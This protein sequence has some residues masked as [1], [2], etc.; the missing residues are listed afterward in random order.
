M[1]VGFFQSPTQAVSRSTITRGM[2]D[3]NLGVSQIY[4]DTDNVNWTEH[5]VMEI[6]QLFLMQY[7]Q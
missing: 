7:I 5:A 6:K 1:R 3:W 4:T 2:H